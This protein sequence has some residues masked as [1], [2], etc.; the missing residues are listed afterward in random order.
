MG[1]VMTMVATGGAVPCLCVRE[2]GA[3]VCGCD[4]DWPTVAVMCQ[5][6]CGDVLEE[7]PHSSVCKGIVMT[8]G[9]HERPRFGLREAMCKGR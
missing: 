4:H 5:G 9:N 1:M 2:R 7:W 3:Q 8:M 6:L